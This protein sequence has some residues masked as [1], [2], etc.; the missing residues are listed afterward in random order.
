MVPRNFP[1]SLLIPTLQAQANMLAWILMQRKAN[2]G[3]KQCFKS[4]VRLESGWADVFC[5]RADEGVNAG[6]DP[7]DGEQAFVT[8]HYVKVLY[9][10]PPDDRVLLCWYSSSCCGVEYRI[11]KLRERHVCRKIGKKALR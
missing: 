8:V 1:P 6:E 7:P 3:R 2:D 4:S 9:L 10:F 5:T 11:G